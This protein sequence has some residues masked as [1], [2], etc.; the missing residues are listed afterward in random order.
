MPGFLQLLRSLSNLRARSRG[1]RRPS[2]L[3]PLNRYE[4]LVHGDGSLEHRRV[5]PE[6][7]LAQSWD[8]DP[9]SK[10][11]VSQCTQNAGNPVN[12][13]VNYVFPIN[14]PFL[15]KRNLSLSSS[16]TLYSF[17][18]EPV[19]Q[20]LRKLYSQCRAP[21]W[22]RPIANSSPFRVTLRLQ[23]DAIIAAANFTSR[24]GGGV[25]GA[26]HD[27]TG[28]ELL[29]AC[30]TL[31]G[32]ATEDAKATLGFRMQAARWSFPRRGPG[33]ARRQEGRKMR[34][35]PELLCAMP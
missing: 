9:H 26:I 15:Q 10:H 4:G 27:A 20:D 33:V 17:S 5:C 34:R 6:S 30:E 11:L 25:D 29:A 35:L 16:S 19:P 28:P 23:V 7:W 8:G 24:G 18:G 2:D 1:T 3:H 22:R 21:V 32:C 12:V 13:T 31:S 14:L